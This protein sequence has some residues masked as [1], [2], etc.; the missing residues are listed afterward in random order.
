MDATELRGALDDIGWSLRQLSRVLEI[1]FATV[2]R[3]S[4]GQKRLPDHVARW[5]TDLARYHQT[6]ALPDGW[7]PAQSVKDEG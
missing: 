6:H 4:T 7:T 5:L 3:W 1:Q 2:E